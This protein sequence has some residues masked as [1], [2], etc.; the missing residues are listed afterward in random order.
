MGD[1]VARLDTC[2]GCR[3]AVNRGN[4]F[5]KTFFLRHLDAKAA[6]FAA[7]LHLHRR[8]VIRRQI[9]GMRIKRRQHAVNRRLDQFARLDLFDVLAANAFKDVA[10]QIQLFIDTR[11]GFAFLRKQG[12]RNL[13]RCDGPCQRAAQS[14]HNEFFHSRLSILVNAEPCLRVQRHIILSDLYIERF[15]A[16]SATP[17]TTS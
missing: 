5:D 8:R 2:L 14:G 1:K 11:I 13:R 10:E 3:G 12:A 15:R 6:E 17:F 4:D 9:A 7:R 16:V